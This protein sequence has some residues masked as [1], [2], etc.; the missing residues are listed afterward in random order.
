MVIRIDS[1]K[2]KAIITLSIIFIIALL[3]LVIPFSIVLSAYTTLTIKESHKAVLIENGTL[4]SI[5][6]FNPIDYFKL[7][8]DKLKIPYKIVNISRFNNTLVTFELPSI[9]HSKYVSIVFVNGSTIAYLFNSTKDKAIIF[10]HG[11]HIGKWEKVIQTQINNYNVTMNESVE[12]ILTPIPG[13]YND[14]TYDLTQDVAFYALVGEVFYV[15]AHG[16]FN[17][18]LGGDIT[19]L[20]IAGSY[21]T[22]FNGAAVC[23]QY[24]EYGGV[25]TTIG[26]VQE[27]GGGAAPDCPVTDWY[28]GWPGFSV[29]ALDGSI[30]YNTGPN[31]S[32]TPGNSGITLGCGCYGV[33]FS[34]P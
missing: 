23:T 10:S 9:F 31:G 12:V 33:N 11:K 26:Y 29:N 5:N 4:N 25:G 24:T 22:A 18:I 14:P 3:I 8:K 28:A 16:I 27:N 6:S 7:D 17:F 21:A 34:F 32:S 19:G 1:L 2:R 15:K 30:E 13:G 20:S